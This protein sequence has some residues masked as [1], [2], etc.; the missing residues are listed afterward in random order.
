MLAVEGT[1]QEGVV[2]PDKPISGRNGQ[3]VIILFLQED[4]EPLIEDSAWGDFAQLLKDCQVHTGIGDLA[5]QHDHYLYGTP[6]QKNE[7]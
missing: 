3:K 7:V 6:K 5:H 1:F 4:N 2:C